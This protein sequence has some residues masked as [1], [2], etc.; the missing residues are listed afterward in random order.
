MWS[1]PGSRAQG[2]A[3]QHI[4]WMGAVPRPEVNKRTVKNAC[5]NAV[6]V[7]VTHKASGIYI[8]IYIYIYAFADYLFA[9]SVL[10]GCDESCMIVRELFVRS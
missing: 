2:R 5:Q 9:A 7:L 4:E 8:Y 6:A 3:V 10:C 1:L